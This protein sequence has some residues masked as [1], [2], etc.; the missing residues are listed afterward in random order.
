M[1]LRMSEKF[2]MLLIDACIMV[3]A[4]IKSIIGNAVAI[5]ATVYS[6]IPKPVFNSCN[7]NCHMQ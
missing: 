2:I 7:E 3:E 5:V 4:Q 6:R 1:R